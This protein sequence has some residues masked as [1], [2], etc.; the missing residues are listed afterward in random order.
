MS[1]HFPFSQEQMQQQSVSLTTNQS[2]FIANTLDL[3]TASLGF[4]LM[5]N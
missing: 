3:K 2:L 5:W 1:F 4:F